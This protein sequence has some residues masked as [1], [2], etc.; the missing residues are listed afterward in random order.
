M[1]GAGLRADIEDSAGN[2]ALLFDYILQKL[3]FDQLIWEF[4][5]EVEPD[6]IHVSYNIGNNRQEVLRASNLEG[7][8]YYE[9]YH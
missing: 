7:K 4:G 3:E 8:T 5:D 1:S 6:W 9:P 2:N